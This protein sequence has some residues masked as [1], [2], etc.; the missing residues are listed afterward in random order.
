MGF[1]SPSS[2]GFDF[3][4]YLRP[5]RKIA[6]GGH[7]TLCCNGFRWNAALDA[8]F[9]Q[10]D[11]RL[12]QSH[13]QRNLISKVY[14][15]RLIIPSATF[16]VAMVDFLINLCILIVIMVWYRFLPGWQVCILAMLYDS[17][18]S[19]EFRPGPLDHLT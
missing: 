5:H 11:R 7:S 14:F 13:Q 17:G 19:G 8:F 10:L 16:V 6:I 4:D 1:D 18:M 12:K 2:R 3:Y 15:P 9:E